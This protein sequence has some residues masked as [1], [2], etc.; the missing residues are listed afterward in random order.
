[1][2]SEKKI[3]EVLDLLTTARPFQI[4]ALG[5]SAFTHANS[6]RDVVRTSNIVALGIAEK[7][8]GEDITGKLALTFYVKKKVP[9][10]ELMA[11]QAIPPTVPDALTGNVAIP[12]DVVEIGEIVP[13]A[14]VTRNSLQAGYSIGHVDV[15]CGTLGAIVTDGDGYFV[16]SNSHVLANSGL[17]KTGDE[18]IYPGGADGGI[19]G[20][21]TIGKLTNFVPFV[22]GEDYINQTDCAI[23]K[24]NED[25]LPQIDFKIKGK[26]V[27][28]G[29]IKPKRGM[30][31]YKVG[32]TTDYT[33][34]EIRDVDLRVPVP[35]G[36]AVGE[37]RFINQVLCTNFTEGGDSG[38]L[39]LDKKTNKAVGLHFCGG[40]RG[41]IFNPIGLVLD[42][43]KVKLVTPRDVALK[44]LNI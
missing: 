25:R 14:N 30:T 31:V 5:F 29:T 21:D 34:G 20:V 19:K 22:S 2:A 39:V 23:A 10:R 27:P 16:L 37:I 18:I 17:G 3:R 24:I 33:E 44:K 42:A 13:E 28:K 35:Y 38:S 8:S 41:S 7:R 11:D 9:L 12:T 43:L 32:R 1:M 36:G 15:T 6:L 4:E 26:G 40:S